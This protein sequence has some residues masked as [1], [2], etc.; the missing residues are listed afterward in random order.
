[1][2]FSGP[3]HVVWEHDLLKPRSLWP[4]SQS[5]LSLRT[6]FCRLT[7][8]VWCRREGTSGGTRCPHHK[9]GKLD[10][11]DALKTAPDG[12]LRFSVGGET[13]LVEGCDR[14]TQSPSLPQIC[15]EFLMGESQTT[16]P[17]K[18]LK[19]KDKCA[20]SFC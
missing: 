12:S 14:E 3:E 9:T 13:N 17:R 16:D 20:C 18:E 6:S 11:I 4:L 1:M 19:R 5:Q 2:G 10:R 8:A 15:E 7:R